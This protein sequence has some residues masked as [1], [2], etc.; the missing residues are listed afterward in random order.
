MF[1]LISPFPNWRRWLFIQSRSRAPR[2]FNES[3]FRNKNNTFYCVSNKNIPT[4]HKFV[5]RSFD[6]EMRVSTISTVA[7]LCMGLKTGKNRYRKFYRYLLSYCLALRK[8]ILISQSKNRVEG[9]SN[10]IT[11]FICYLFWSAPVYTVC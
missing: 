4:G 1:P 9:R 6:C 11:R 8:K 5:L 2:I 7:L 10:H 3:I